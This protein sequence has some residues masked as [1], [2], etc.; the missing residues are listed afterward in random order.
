MTIKEKFAEA[1]F[2]L[3]KFNEYLTANPEMFSPGS[4]CHKAYHQVVE[5]C[6]AAIDMLNKVRKEAEELMRKIH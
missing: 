3:D 4:Y 2:A 6:D 5:D 1:K